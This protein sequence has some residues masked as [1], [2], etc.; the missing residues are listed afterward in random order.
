MVRRRENTHKHLTR[1][2][3]ATPLVC[4]VL[5]AAMIRTHV[6]MTIVAKGKEAAP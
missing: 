5:P 4:A 1:H 6:V 3:V 2:A